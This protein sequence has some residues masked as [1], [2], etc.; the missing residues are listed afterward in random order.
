MVTAKEPDD[1]TISKLKAKDAKGGLTELNTTQLQVLKLRIQKFGEDGQ[2][3][4]ARCSKA[5]GDRTERAHLGTLSLDPTRMGARN[6]ESQNENA[7]SEG[8]RGL[9]AAMRKR[10]RGPPG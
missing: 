1:T 6:R 3:N 8:P 10:G 4:V 7:A 2:L 5:G 9:L